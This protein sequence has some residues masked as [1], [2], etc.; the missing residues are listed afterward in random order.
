MAD[1]WSW[2]DESRRRPLIYCTAHCCRRWIALLSSIFSLP[3]FSLFHA[4]ERVMHQGQ[5][6]LGVGRI[7]VAGAHS[8]G[9]E[10]HEE[11]REGFGEGSEG[12]MREEKKPPAKI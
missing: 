6:W 5:A 12:V 7:R 3:V 8:P 10:T 11:V 2:G 4:C 1:C 9:L